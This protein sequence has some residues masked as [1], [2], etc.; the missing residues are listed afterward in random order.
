MSPEQLK[1]ELKSL[2]LEAVEKDEPTGGLSDDEVLFGPES[3][4]DMPCK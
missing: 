2:V 3:R 4:L 1:I